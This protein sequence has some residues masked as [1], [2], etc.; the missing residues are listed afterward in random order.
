MS[1]LPGQRAAQRTVRA[2]TSTQRALGRSAQASPG[3]LSAFT[4]WG[5]IDGQQV[6]VDLS[7]PPGQQVRPSRLPC[8]CLGRCRG[9]CPPLDEVDEDQ[10]DEGQ[11]QDQGDETETPERQG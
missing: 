2:I 5:W 6:D 4:G 7:A 3:G 1:A 8:G 11:D 9:Q 10:D